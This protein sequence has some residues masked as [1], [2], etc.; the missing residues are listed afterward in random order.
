[1]GREG[2]ETSW[3]LAQQPAPASGARDALGGPFWVLENPENPQGPLGPAVAG[4]RRGG[5]LDSP[6]APP[7]VWPSAGVKAAGHL[8]CL[9]T[10][11]WVGMAPKGPGGNL[12]FGWLSGGCSSPVCHS[13]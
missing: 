2:A 12:G 10:Q 13:V 3:G 9:G 1:M 11:L 4:R 7:I 5:A 6:E 8:Q